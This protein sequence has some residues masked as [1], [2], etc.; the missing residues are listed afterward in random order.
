[1]PEPMPPARDRRHGR[2]RRIAKWQT[3]ASEEPLRAL[4]LVRRYLACS[5]R[6]SVALVWL[7]E[8][9]EQIAEPVRDALIDHFVVNL[10]ELLADFCLDF[11]IKLGRVDAHRHI[12]E[13]RR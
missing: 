5:L 7:F 6:F 2:H 3:P 8:T 1:M 10:A 4:H 12:A 9:V 11:R 13:L